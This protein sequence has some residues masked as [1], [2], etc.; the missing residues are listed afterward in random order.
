MRT[1]AWA[2]GGPGLEVRC[3]LRLAGLCTCWPLPCRRAS[4]THP[5]PSPRPPAGLLHSLPQRVTSFCV[6]PAPVALPGAAGAVVPL[7]AATASGSLELAVV[8][9][10]GLLPLHLGLS[11]SLAAHPGPVQVRRRW[12]RLRR[13]A[14]R[15]KRGRQR[16]MGASR[17]GRVARSGGLLPTSCGPPMM[18]PA[19]C[20]RRACAGWA[21]PRAWRPTAARRPAAAGATRCWSRVS[22]GVLGGLGERGAWAGDRGTQT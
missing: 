12:L 16:C 21:P 5:S 7:A 10:G 2:R 17:A 1:P 13:R 3:A 9:Q 4:A 22:P 6:G 11:A 20:C 8:Q 15:W 18:P 14:S 19:P